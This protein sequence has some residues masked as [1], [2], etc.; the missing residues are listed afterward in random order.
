MDNLIN[1]KFSFGKKW[2]CIGI[3]A[4]FFSVFAGLIYGI[5]LIL[6]KEYR[7][8]GAT[9]IVFSIIWKILFFWFIIPW[10]IEKYGFLPL[11]VFF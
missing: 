10:F 11:E 8:E 4:G 6:E 1:G 7:K 5:A 3:V 2:F 9:I